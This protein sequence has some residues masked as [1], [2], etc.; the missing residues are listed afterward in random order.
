MSKKHLLVFGLLFIT[1]PA[2]AQNTQCSNRPATDDSNAC[3]N[4]RFVHDHVP[5]VVPPSSISLNDGQIIIGNSS[6]V[7]QGRT[8][9]GDITNTDTG[10]VTISPQAVTNTKIAPGAADT[11]KGSLNGTS[12]TDLAIPAC[13]GNNV[14]QYTTSI[15]FTCA[16]ITASPV[17]ASRA[18]AAAQNL[19]AFTS[20]KTLGYATAGDGGGATFLK[21]GAVPFKDTYVL[22]GSI[23]PGT[24]YTNGTYLGVPMGGGDGLGCAAAVTVSGTVVTAVDITGNYC[25]A[26]AV[27]NALTPL[28]SAV[29]GTGSGAL[30]TVSTISTQQASFI[31]AGGNNW[32]YVVDEGSFLNVRQFGAKLDWNGTDGTAT[33]DLNSFKS[34][35]AF[36][37]VPFSGSAAIIFGAKVIVPK[38]AAY[39]CAS[40]AQFATLQVPAGVSIEG[41]SPYGAATLKQ[42]TGASSN[43]HFISLC[44]PNS[45]VG[46]FGCRL[47][48]ISLIMT[49]TSAN[50]I[51]AVY[52]N[53][54]QQFPILD[55]VYIQPL[56]RSCLYYEIG[57]GGASNAIFENVDCEGDAASTNNG[58]TIAANVGGTQVVFRNW[59]MGCAPTTCSRNAFANPD[60]SAANLIFDTIHIEGTTTGISLGGDGLSVVRNVTGGTACTSLI[61]LQST[62][63]NGTVL[64][65]NIS[66]GSCT[67]TVTNGHGGGSNFLG[68]ILTPIAFNP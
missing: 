36:A 27:G 37:A 3:A 17:F 55:N 15:G 43:E 5:A 35:M 34:A 42:C 65:E 13:A 28:N 57:R 38:G 11:V 53:S 12:V 14:L 2:W 10:V 25:A 29:G 46:E 52:S 9:S 44:N 4:T 31:D 20:I 22:T 51:A 6:N 48:D 39:L 49:G 62:N 24:G 32:Q 66:Q 26:Y 61:V 30:F 19:S 64:F 58:V 41:G 33:N 56:T 59:V 40:P 18:A 47:K 54:A 21:V 7:G 8:L 60:G 67:T 23:T 50:N 45:S 1:C 16:A 63:N 68:N